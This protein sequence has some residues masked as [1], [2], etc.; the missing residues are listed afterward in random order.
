MITPNYKELALEG[1]FLLLDVKQAAAAEHNRRSAHVVAALSAPTAPA[2]QLAS[3][4][5]FDHR[6]GHIIGAV[7][8]IGDR[9]V[10]HDIDGRAVAECRTAHE[11]IRAIEQAATDASW[12]SVIAEAGH[13][14]NDRPQTS[15]TDD[16]NGWPAAIARAQA[17]QPQFAASGATSEA[18]R[19]WTEIIRGIQNGA[20]A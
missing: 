14:R 19:N 2:A 8:A 10:A 9:F 3:F 5:V 12:A 1:K 13:G 15:Q 4:N 20:S 6:D 17:E 7:K 16:N 18:D 11:A